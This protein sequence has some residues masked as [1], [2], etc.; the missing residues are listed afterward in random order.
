MHPEYRFENGH[1][2]LQA[3][4]EQTTVKETDTGHLTLDIN[5]T[6]PDLML[7]SWIGMRNKAFLV[8]DEIQMMKKR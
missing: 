4:G 3:D 1:G 5:Y 7:N 2:T 8:T 6:L